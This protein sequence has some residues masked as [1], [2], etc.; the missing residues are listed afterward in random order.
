MV[1]DMIARIT[2]MALLVCAGILVIGCGGAERSDCVFIPPVEGVTT[3]FSFIRLEDSIA[4]ISSREALVA[5]FTR[6][7]VIR[8]YLFARKNYPDDSVF[9]KTLYARFSNPGFDSLLMETHRIFGDGAALRAQFEEAFNNIKYY[10]PD[11]TPPTV[12]TVISGLESDLV[13]TDS[14]IIVGLD[15]Y[16]GESGKYRPR[17]YDYLLTRYDPEDIVPSCL[18]IYGIG[19]R[20]NK[21]SLDDR[22]VLADMV[23]YGKSF[24]FAKHMLPCVSD[25]VF[26]WYSQQEI[27]G[28][29]VNQDLVWARFVEDEILYEKSHLVKQRYLGERPHTLEVGE[30]C[31]GRIAQWVGW[32][33]VRQYMEKHTDETLPQLMA[34]PDAQQLFKE[35]GYRPRHGGDF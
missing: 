6:H 32:Q 4:S 17:L 35:S 28:A 11:F 16:L 13:V 18:L 2:C 25:S 23:A 9:V 14:L 19:D 1:K 29:E 3:D 12:K 10:Y 5:F 15:Y 8:D 7:P 20:Y 27:H 30:K 31:P 33:I 26:I 24:Y 34:L 22:T 21:T